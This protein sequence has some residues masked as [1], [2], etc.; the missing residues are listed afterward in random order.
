MCLLQRQDSGHQNRLEQKAEDRHKERMTNKNRFKQSSIP[1]FKKYS[2]LLACVSLNLR[3][4]YRRNHHYIQLQ[5]IRIKS[6]NMNY[7][8]AIATILLYCWDVMRETLVKSMPIML[9]FHT[10]KRNRIN[11]R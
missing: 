2:H 4:F 7:L 1:N 9:Q 5:T 11:Q 3:R 10:V 8:A 6:P